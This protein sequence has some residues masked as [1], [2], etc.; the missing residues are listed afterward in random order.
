MIYHLS[1]TNPVYQQHFF[2]Q[3][4]PLKFNINFISNFSLLNILN[5]ELSMFNAALER[6]L[7]LPPIDIAVRQNQLQDWR[8]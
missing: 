7:K 3:P 2:T 8:Y 4:L 6:L 1:D 5:P